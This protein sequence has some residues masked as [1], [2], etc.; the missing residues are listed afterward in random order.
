[1]FVT[2]AQLL[3]KAWN[4]V[5]ESYKIIISNLL[6]R[7]APNFDSLAF[8]CRW[9]EENCIQPYFLHVHHSCAYLIPAAPMASDG[10]ENT[11]IIQINFVSASLTPELL[12]ANKIQNWS[13]VIHSET[14]DHYNI[15][16]S[17][18]LFRWVAEICF[19]FH[20]LRNEGVCAPANG[21]KLI[22]FILFWK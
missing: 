22:A 6:S 10:M 5:K 16:V 8:W 17:L 4:S 3:K 14:C 13:D 21:G 9:R 18:N 15:E 2:A 11:L 20:K 12:N 1:M 7:S 19:Y